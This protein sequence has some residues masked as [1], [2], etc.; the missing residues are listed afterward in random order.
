MA[1]TSLWPAIKSI[2]SVKMFLGR[3]KRIK[4]RKDSEEEVK[5]KMKRMKGKE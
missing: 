1:T 5:I 2:Q 4:K 3:M